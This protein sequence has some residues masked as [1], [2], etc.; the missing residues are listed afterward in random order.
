MRTYLSF[1]VAEARGRET[2]RGGEGGGQ[3]EGKE[4][5]DG[6]GR[7]RP[8]FGERGDGKKK[9]IDRSYRGTQYRTWE[10]EVQKKGRSNA[11]T[12]NLISMGSAAV[13]LASKF[14]SS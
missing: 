9:L 5:G 11:R 7:E 8:G 6:E 14:V 10:S 13:C 3:E 1:I 12:Q 2:K 4:G